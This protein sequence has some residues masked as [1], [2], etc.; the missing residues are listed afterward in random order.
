M[1]TRSFRPTVLATIS[2]SSAC[3]LALPTLGASPILSAARPPD[4]GVVLAAWHGASFQRNVSVNRSTEVNRNVNVNVNRS[5]PGWGGV[6]AGAAVGAS[7]GVAAGA[8]ARSASSPAY[9]YTYPYGYP[10]PP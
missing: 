4:R 10:P 7:V 8:A 3:I 6:A 2:L 5:G 9:V 1:S